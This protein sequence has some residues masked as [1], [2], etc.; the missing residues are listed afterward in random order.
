M[1]WPEWV[2]SGVRPPLRGAPWGAMGGPMGAP[3]AP[4]RPLG[5]PWGPIIYHIVSYQIRSHHLMEALWGPKG[6][7]GGPQGGQ[8]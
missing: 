2:P 7:Q 5:A 1:M 6:P 3:W 8:G 4:W